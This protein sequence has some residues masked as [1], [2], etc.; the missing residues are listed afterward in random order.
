M[1]P[2]SRIDLIEV[3]AAGPKTA[4]TFH[5]SRNEFDACVEHRSLWCL[6]QIIFDSAAFT[7]T[8]IRAV[9]VNAVREITDHALL[10]FIPSDTP[11]FI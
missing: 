5:I 9:R 10:D 1:A 6:I 3:K 4:G 7:A 8:E 11:A 2:G